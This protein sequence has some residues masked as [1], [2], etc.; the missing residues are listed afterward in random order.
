MQAIGAVILSFYRKPHFNYT[1]DDIMVNRKHK[2]IQPGAKH[3]DPEG[4]FL[5]LSDIGIAYQ[6][7]PNSRGL[8]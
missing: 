6:Q 7:R 1:F 2:T 4:G 3:R 5:V 8:I